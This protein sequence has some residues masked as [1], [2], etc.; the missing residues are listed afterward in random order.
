MHRHRHGRRLEL[1]EPH[2]E[3]IRDGERVGCDELVAAREV[4]PAQRRQ[5]DC[6]ALPGL[7]PLDL[8]IVHLH[9]PHA[10]DEAARLDAQHVPGGDRAGPERSRRDRAGAGQREDAIDPEPRRRRGV[11][12]LHRHSRQRSAQLVEAGARLGRHRHDLRVRDE[13]PCLLDRE[14]DGLLVDRV[15]LRDRDHTAV[16]AEQPQHRQVLVRL[17]PRALARVDHEQE[18]IDARRAG[19]HRAHE[20]LV[21]RDVD[22]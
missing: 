18:E 13:L 4:S 6:D 19:D 5:V 12:L 3:A 22:E 8:R 15:D 17:R 14:R 20:A 10:R 2:V 9:R 11:A 21:P 1:V 16:D 7:R